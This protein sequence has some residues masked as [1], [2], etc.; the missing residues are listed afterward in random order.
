M[1]RGKEQGVSSKDSLA[2]LTYSPSDLAKFKSLVDEASHIVI[3]QPERIDPDS[4]GSALALTQLLRESGKQVTNYAYGEVAPSYSHFPG[5]DVFTDKL[6]AEFDFTILVDC[7]GPSQLIDTF[8]QYRPAFERRPFVIID[9]HANREPMPFTTLDLIDIA[10]AATGQQIYELAAHFGWQLT[11][12]SA[13]SLAASIKADTLNLS[14][15][16]VTPRVVRVLANLVELGADLEQL[17]INIERA[18]GLSANQLKLKAKVL[19]RTTFHADSRIALTYLTQ[20]EYTALDADSPLDEQVKH[21][22]RR[23]K[24]VQVAGLLTQRGPDRF[25]VSMRA[26]IPVAGPVATQFG[27]GGHDKAASFFVEAANID[28]AIKTATRALT[29]AV[30]EYDQTD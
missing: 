23:L 13:Y 25:K 19:G 2:D 14:V 8:E 20:A 3:L 28:Q 6:P 29:K 1:T 9:H 24:E 18:G 17:R 7:G 11:A 27:G 22:L 5:S 16:T 10:A 21:E 4:V 15:S 12:D 30:E 26:D